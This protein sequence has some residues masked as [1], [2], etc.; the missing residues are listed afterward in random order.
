VQYEVLEQLQ[1]QTFSRV[2]H[3]DNEVQFDNQWILKHIQC[4]C[5]YVYI[6]EIIGNLRNLKGTPLIKAERRISSGPEAALPE[7][8]IPSRSHTWTF[9]EFATVKGSVTIRFFG[10][11]DGFCSETADLYSIDPTD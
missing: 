5:G 1:G 9:F 2:T 10:S 6:D 4:C 7:G 8:E 11:S 3:N